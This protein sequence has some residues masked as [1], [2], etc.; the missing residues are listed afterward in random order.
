MGLWPRP[1]APLALAWWREWDKAVA[2]PWDV[3][4]PGSSS[5]SDTGWGALGFSPL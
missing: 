5:I 1:R 3:C 4:T 2:L